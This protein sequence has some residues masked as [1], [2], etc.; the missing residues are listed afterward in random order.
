M[1][2]QQKPRALLPAVRA[3]AERPRPQDYGPCRRV[4]VLEEIESEYEDWCST[5]DLT[6]GHPSN[7]WYPTLGPK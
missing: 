7:V 5:H 4:R 3:R 1:R 6:W 2:G